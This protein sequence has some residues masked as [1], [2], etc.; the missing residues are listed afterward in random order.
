MA[1][2]IKPVVNIGLGALE[3]TLSAGV[4]S[5]TLFSKEKIECSL[6]L[7]LGLAYL[8]YDGF[9]RIEK[10]KIQLSYDKF[11]K[12]YQKDLEKEER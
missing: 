12:Q 6:L 11:V 7:G 4:F 5:Y 3:V 8:C 9:E 2:K 10:G 1:F